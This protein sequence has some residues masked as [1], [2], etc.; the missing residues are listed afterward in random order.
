VP[1]WQVQPVGQLVFGPGGE[2]DRR[3]AAV[4]GL[5]TSLAF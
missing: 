1:G 2:Q 5:R 4:I 3:R